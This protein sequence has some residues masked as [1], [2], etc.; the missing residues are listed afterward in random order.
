MALIEKYG[1]NF[2]NDTRTQDFNLERR[3]VHSREKGVL[4]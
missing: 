3:N 1:L 2:I 4:A